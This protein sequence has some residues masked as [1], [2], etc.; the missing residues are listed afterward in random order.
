MASTTTSLSKINNW[1]NHTT[2]QIESMLKKE[3][4]KNLIPTTKQKQAAKVTTGYQEY[5]LATSI[6]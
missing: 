6:K 1:L 4:K 2:S 5:C 3:R